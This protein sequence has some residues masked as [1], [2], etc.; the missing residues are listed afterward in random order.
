MNEIW[1]PTHIFSDNYSV[2]NLGNIRRETPYK[3]MYAGKNLKPQISKGYFHVVLH[4]DSVKKT[5]RVH[6]LVAIAF[7]GPA[8]KGFQ[9]NHKDT[10]KL[11]NNYSNLEYLTCK[12]NIQHAVKN[13]L[14]NPPRGSKNAMAKLTE[15][16]VV[17]I[18]YLYSENFY[19]QTTLAKIY[20]VDPSVISE[21][22]TRKSWKHV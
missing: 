11:N 22:I 21:V 1:K 6:I 9:C 4:K 20:H 15:R 7:L 17:S 13:G 16:D 3:G 8:I 2:S 5:V 14:W 12:Q 18:R 10:N 19:N